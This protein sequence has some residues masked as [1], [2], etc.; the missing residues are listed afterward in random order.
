MASVSRLNSEVKKYDRELCAER[1]AYGRTVIRRKTVHY[2]RFNMDGFD[3]I[4][5][6]PA[7]HFI[8][9]LTHNWQL[10]GNYAE[11]G[12]EPVLNRLKAMDL[13]QNDKMV[14]QMIADQEKQ[15]QIKEKDYKNNVESFLIDFRRQFARSFNDVNTSQMKFDRRTQNGNRK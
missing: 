14:E 7:K 3:L 10:D 2:D 13:W 15:G 4:V 1:D 9:A 8:M 5:S 12:I 11:W 6:R